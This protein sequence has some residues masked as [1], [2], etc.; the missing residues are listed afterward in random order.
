MEPLQALAI[1]DASA[2]RALLPRQDHILAAQ[3]VEALRAVLE[4]QAGAS[5]PTSPPYSS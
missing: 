5:E 1:L 3:A 4:P 2:A